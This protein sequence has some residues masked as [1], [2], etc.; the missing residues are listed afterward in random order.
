MPCMPYLKQSR[1]GYSGCSLKF[2]V[3]LA[4]AIDKDLGVEG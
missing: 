1:L 2:M 3:N 4:T